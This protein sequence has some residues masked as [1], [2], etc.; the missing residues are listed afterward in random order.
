M[1]KFKAD[2]NAN[3]WIY[4]YALDVSGYHSFDDISYTADNMHAISL[5][6][7]TDSFIVIN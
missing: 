4:Q 3:E 5:V 6:H 2:N 1:L 7:G